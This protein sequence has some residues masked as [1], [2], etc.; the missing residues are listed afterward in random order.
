MVEVVSPLSAD[1]YKAIESAIED[2]TGL[3]LKG[4]SQTDREKIYVML[5]GLT[6]A[7]QSVC[8]K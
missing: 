6:A 2:L 8:V 7:L 3:L 1:H 5:A 4:Q